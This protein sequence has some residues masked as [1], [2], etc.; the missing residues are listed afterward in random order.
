MVS[1]GSRN[2]LAHFSLIAA[3]PTADTHQASNGL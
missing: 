1:G 3:L 2:R